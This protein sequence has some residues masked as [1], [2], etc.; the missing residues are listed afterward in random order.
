MDADGF[1][2]VDLPDT[3]AGML[4]QAGFL[5]ARARPMAGSVVGRGLLVNAAVLCNINP[6]FPTQLAADIAKAQS[7]LADATEKDKAAYRADK[8]RVCSGCHPNFDPY[9][10][11]LENFDTIALY[12]TE[13]AKGRPIDAAVTLPPM[14]GCA[15]VSGAVEMAA[16]FTKGD[17]FTN[18]V[19]RNVMGY[20]LAQTTV[21]VSTD[22]CATRAVVDRFNAGGEKTFTSLVR[23]I[24][25]S[26][27]LAART[28]G[29][30]P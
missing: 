17:T 20:A 11:A 30:A 14:A 4:T 12:R 1:A 28:A 13:D 8:S 22:S 21:G 10:L 7:L 9:G 6:A 25:V 15:K 5:V 27:T 16:A 3:R 24:A 19:V 29:G 26:Q 2:A 23:E 18:C